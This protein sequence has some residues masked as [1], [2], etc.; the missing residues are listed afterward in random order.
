MSGF[1]NV[2]GAI[3]CTHAAIR[4][5]SENEVA[6]INHEHFHSLNVNLVCDADMLLT[7]AV[8]RWPGSTH[9]LFTLRHS[10]VGCRLEASAVHDG[11]LLDTDNSCGNPKSCRFIY[12]FY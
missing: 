9:D 6:F 12:F 2:I 3:D 5:P 8:A 7:N 4:A 1:P 10:S 11:W